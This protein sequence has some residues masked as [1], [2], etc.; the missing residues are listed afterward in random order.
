MATRFRGFLPVVV[1]VETGGFDAQRHALLEIAAIPLHMDASDLLHPGP[2]HHA[3]I[4][5]F[6]G[7]LIDPK[8]LEIT[9]IDPF[10]PLRAAREEK[11]ALDHVFGPVREAVKRHGCQRAI[12]VGHNAAF[13]LSFLNAAVRRT[14]HKRSPFHPFSTLDTVSLAALAYGQT[15]LAKAVRAAGLE[16][17]SREAHSAV[18]DT[19]ITAQ[20]FCMIVNRWHAVAGWP[21]RQAIEAAEADPN[22]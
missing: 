14:E 20:L 22:S 9:G 21:G 12:L 11:A 4:K 7:A 5:A 10:H 18:Y 3:H 15:V 19:R 17:D 6:A 8:S 13:D 2:T 1:D 16:W